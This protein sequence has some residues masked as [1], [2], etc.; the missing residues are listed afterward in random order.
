M[1]NALLA[2]AFVAYLSYG[3]RAFSFLPMS[4]ILERTGNYLWQITGLE[5][6]YAE[7]I[8]TVIEDMKDAKPHTF[9]TV[10]EYLR[11]FMIK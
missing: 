10:L 4:H 6:Y 1:S 7:S 5:L 2:T 3:E 9:I 8:E 11:K